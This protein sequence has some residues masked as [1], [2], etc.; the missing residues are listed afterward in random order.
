MLRRAAAFV[1]H[2]PSLSAGASGL[3]SGSALGSESVSVVGIFDTGRYLRVMRYCGI[4]TCTPTPRTDSRGELSQA[5]INVRPGGIGDGVAQ[6]SLLPVP[7]PAG[8]SSDTGAEPC[9]CQTTRH[10]RTRLFG[11]SRE[12]GYRAGV[13]PHAPPNNPNTNNTTTNRCEHEVQWALPNNIER[14]Q[15]L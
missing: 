10:P 13:V 2:R 11:G 5:A 4:Y 12:H 15:S 9:Q 14:F 1:R 8:H 6:L 3:L 7:E